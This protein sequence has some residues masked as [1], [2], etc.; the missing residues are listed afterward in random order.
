MTAK[1]KSPR[2]RKNGLVLTAKQLPK[3]SYDAIHN[4]PHGI[5]H[6]ALHALLAAAADLAKRSGKADW[7]VH[8][9]RLKL[10]YG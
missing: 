5:R 2:V 10:T 1:K 3:P 7:Y 6:L 9:K 8:G 4:L